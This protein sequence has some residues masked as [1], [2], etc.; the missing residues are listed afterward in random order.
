[1]SLNCLQ[2]EEEIIY[3]P[4]VAF[5][6]AFKGESKFLAVVGGSRGGFLVRVGN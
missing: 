3:G 5:G 6:G 2:K 4:V 1:M